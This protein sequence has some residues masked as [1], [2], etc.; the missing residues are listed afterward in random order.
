MP[1]YDDSDKAARYQRSYDRFWTHQ[2]L[3]ALDHEQAQD[4]ELAR[5]HEAVEAELLD[6]QVHQAEMSRDDEC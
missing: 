1:Y 4:R 2:E 5:E 3:L 6:E